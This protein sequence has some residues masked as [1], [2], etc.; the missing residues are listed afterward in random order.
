PHDLASGRTLRPPV[1]SEPSGH[2]GAAPAHRRGEPAAMT[3]SILAADAATSH[4]G[5]TLSLFAAV[6][7]VS[8]GVTSWAGRY[9]KTRDEFFTAGRGLTGR[10][11]GLAMAGDSLSASAVLG[12]VCLVSLFGYDGFMFGI[13]N[14]VAFA[15]LLLLAGFLRNS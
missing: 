5:L 11:N 13:A 9:Q 3:A 10:Q 14:V 2:R 15:L 7:V 8:L 12:S 4:R 1:P 6:V